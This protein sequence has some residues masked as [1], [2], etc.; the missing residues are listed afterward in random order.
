MGRFYIVSCENNFRSLDVRLIPADRR[1]KTERLLRHADLIQNGTIKLP[2]DAHWRDVWDSERRQF[3]HG[4]Y[5]DQIDGMTLGLDFIRENPELGKNQ[6]RCAGVWVNSRGIPTFVISEEFFD[7]RRKFSVG[8][9]PNMRPRCATD[10]RPDVGQ[11]AGA[12]P[13][14]SDGTSHQTIA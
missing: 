10:K 14:A 3:P 1:S 2:W 4:P 9:K 8:N 12:A 7:A 13:A 11:P 5:D 6:Q